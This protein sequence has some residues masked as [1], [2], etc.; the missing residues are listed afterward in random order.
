MSRAIHLSDDHT[1]EIV[2]AADDDAK[3]LIGRAVDIFGKDLA[4]AI[5]EGRI[6]AGDIAYATTRTVVKINGRK[7]HV[8]L[9]FSMQNV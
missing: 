5:D 7:R 8:S 1:I 6:V 9:R 3:T 4:E 2:D